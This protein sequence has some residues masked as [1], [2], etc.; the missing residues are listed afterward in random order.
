MKSFAAATALLGAGLLAGCLPDVGQTAP[1]ECQVEADCPVA[2]QVCDEGLCWGGAP[3][4]PYAA[5][6]GPPASSRGDLIAT[7]VPELDIPDDGGFGDLLIQAPVTI[8]GRVHLGCSAYTLTCDPTTTVAATITLQR[9]SRIP[10]GPLYVDSATSG[11]AM[12]NGDSFSIDVPRLALGDDPYTLTITPSDSDPIVPDGPTPAELAPPLTIQVDATDN[13]TGLDVALGEGTLRTVTGRVVD[14]TGVGVEG[15]RVSAQGRF[16]AARPLERVSTVAV[17]DS[18]GIYTIF[19]AEAAYPIVDIV[20][21]PTDNTGLTLRLR[22]VPADQASQ[23]VGDLRLP[24]IGSPIQVTLPVAG[25]TGAGQSAPVVGASVVVTTQLDD[26]AHPTQ[27]TT[28]QATGSTDA[29]GNATLSLIPAGTTLRDY[30]VRVSPSP[31]SEFASVWDQVVQIGSG[32]GVLAQLVLPHRLA[33][34]GTL[35]DADGA[36]AT[37][38]TM[39]AKPALRF[40][41]ALDTT[42]QGVISNLQP[43]SATTQEDGSFFVWVDPDL[44]GLAASY[45]LEAQPPAGARVPRWTFPDVSITDTSANV[46]KGDLTL[47]PGRHVR[48]RIVDRLGEVVSGSEVRIYEPLTDVSLCNI[49]GLSADC[50]LPAALRALDRSDDQGIVRLVLPDPP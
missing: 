9:P 31:T 37:G 11:A 1:P 46:D 22:D 43:P 41:L 24:G 12:A 45:D 42:T 23:Q 33:V 6:I 5:L 8:S 30:H 2:G 16:D 20:G 29:Q 32:G 13:V 50:V 48:G 44:A 4:G 17:T 47:P 25:V 18:Y 26:P 15:V 49:A 21:H 34:T 19:V 27:V 28:F 38:V 14:A 7:E 3:A 10:G 40:T 39:V 36:P 35:L